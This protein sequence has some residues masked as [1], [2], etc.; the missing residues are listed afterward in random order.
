MKRFRDMALFLLIILS[1]SIITVGITYRY[2]L[3]PVD[4]T[5]MVQVIVIENNN[6]DDVTSMLNKKKLIR[7]PKV[8]KIYLK[9]NNI[10]SFKKGTYE[11]IDTMSSEKIASILSKKQN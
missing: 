5:G 2:N 1:F 10:K 3:S 8:F 6:I 9:I 7:N 11:L 4:Q